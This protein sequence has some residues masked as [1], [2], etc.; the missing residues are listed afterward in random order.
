MQIPKSQSVMLIANNTVFDNSMTLIAGCADILNTIVSQNVHVI[1]GVKVNSDDQENSVKQQ[2][3]EAVPNLKQHHIIFFEQ[4][5]SVYNI[6]RQ[7]N[8]NI[9]YH[10]NQITFDQL[11][12]FIKSEMIQGPITAYFK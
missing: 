1:L 9:C 4:D 2:L 12:Q 11:K 5:A 3:Q 10:S 8:P 6:A 7:F